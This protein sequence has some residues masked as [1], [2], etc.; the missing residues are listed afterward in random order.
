MYSYSKRSLDN[1]GQCH[2]DLQTLFNEVIK[3]F[4]CSIVYGHRTPEEQKEL[5]AQGRTK[6]G[7]IVTHKDGI[8]NLSKHNYNPS[9]AIDAVPWH[10]QKPHIRWNEIES[11]YYFAGYVLATAQQ[12]YECGKITSMIRAGADWNRNNNVNDETFI[13]I[14]HFEIIEF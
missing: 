10:P 4:D 13:Y 6:A 14:V 2:I 9:L 5:Y 11:L 7:S 3:Y 8:N 1:L 12:L